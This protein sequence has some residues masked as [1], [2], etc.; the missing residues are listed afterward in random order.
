MRTH[1]TTAVVTAALLVLGTG[2]AQAKVYKWVDENGVTQYTQYPPPKG[3]AK[4]ITVPSAPSADPA[5]QLKELQQRVEA[6]D[7][8]RKERALADEETAEQRAA[9]ERLVADCKRIRSELEVISNNP[10]LLEEGQ[11]G[12]RVRMTEERR[13]ERIAT[14]KQQI[15]DYCSDG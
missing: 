6:L 3:S 13:L 7:K 15:R 2:V 9:R 11:D 4:E 10:R 1:V 12:T 14:Y 5:T 8:Q